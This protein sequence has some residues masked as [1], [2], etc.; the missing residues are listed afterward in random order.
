[1]PQIYK[2]RDPGRIKAVIRYSGLAVSVVSFFCL[3]YISFPFISWKVF[4]EPAFAS[5]D[6]ETPIPKT[7]VLT[8]D[9]IKTLFTS[10]YQTLNLDYYDAR[11]WFPKL[12]NKYEPVTDPGI[13]T[14]FNISIPKLRIKYANVS[15][16]DTDLSKHLILYPG[17]V[18]PPGT[19]NAVIF[20]HSTIPSFFNPLDYKTIF[21]TAHTL[22]TGD[23]IYVTVNAKEYIYKV[24]TIN[25]T[26]PDDTDI[27]I[28][29]NDASYLTILTC[30]PP[31]T[32]WKRLAIKARLVD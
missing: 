21:A 12:N 23:S 22:K 11:N 1:M 10:A 20:G 28:Q 17:T 7:T 30:T 9:N 27:F 4:F 13:I 8:K 14:T 3:L 32:T 2:K 24:E 5:G 18:I 15:T 6:L 26:T 19:G 31:G 25:I 16:I 29:N